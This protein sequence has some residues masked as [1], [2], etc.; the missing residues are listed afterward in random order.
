MLKFNIVYDVINENR[1][2]TNYYIVI[3]DAIMLLKH[4]NLNSII[5]KVSL[6]TYESLYPIVI[7]TI[8]L[9]KN[10]TVTTKKLNLN[11]SNISELYLFLNLFNDVM[12]DENENKYIIQSICDILCETSNQ[13]LNQ[14]SNQAH[15]MKNTQQ[16]SRIF[17][18]NNNNSNNIN[19][20]DV[21]IKNIA[22]KINQTLSKKSIIQKESEKG[23]EQENKFDI[24]HNKIDSD[25]DMP[26]CEIEKIRKDVEKLE[27]TKEIMDTAITSFENELEEEKENLNDYV[28]KMN[29]DSKKIKL[30]EEKLDREIS[31]FISERDYTYKKIYSAMISFGAIDFN[32]IPSLFISKFPV[33]LFMNGKD[34]NGVDVR[35]NLFDTENDEEQFYSYKLLYNILTEEISLTDVE[36]EK[37]EELIC[38]F[39]NFLPNGYQLITPDDVMKICNKNSDDEKHIMFRE[40]ET[41]GDELK[42]HDSNIAYEQ[43]NF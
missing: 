21:L 18:L 23:N 31:V 1:S 17:A 38:E 34:C 7:E 10:Y 9:N 2:Y 8:N 24:I 26:D 12:D 22:S 16:K 14:T 42:E 41:E 6:E 27:K 29:E 33:F 43:R 11:L 4:T 37:Y 40:E 32:K 30:E 5:I 3:H 13:T 35:K 15:I 28:E 36:D 25:N 39:I 19:E 20:N